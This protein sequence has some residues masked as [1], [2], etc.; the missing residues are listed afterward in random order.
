[1]VEGDLD[2]GLVAQMM[3]IA[4]DPSLR[5]AVYDR[6]G[7]YFHQC[8]NRLNS[9]KLS[10]YLVKRQADGELSD[11]W[12][13]LDRHYGELEQKVDTVQR[14]C[15]PM[16][17][18]RVRIGLELLIDDRRS[19]WTEVWTARHGTLRFVGPPGP[20]VARLDVDRLGHALDAFVAWRAEQ[21]GEAL[22]VTL[23]WWSESGDVRLSWEESPGAA[24]PDPAEDSRWSLP[25]L[26]RVIAEH[27]GETEVRDGEGWRL[28]LRWP[29]S[30]PAC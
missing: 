10:L 28:A 4:R 21:G 23:R 14:L 25:W 15:R 13:C 5:A 17:L 30:P 18:S 3:E 11:A 19:A 9:L 26:I 1:M 27:G 22:D 8:R 24:D 7:E 16:T 2:A 20:V 12:S 29:A 6:I